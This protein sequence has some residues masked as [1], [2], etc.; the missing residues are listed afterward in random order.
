[1][2]DLEQNV[3]RRPLAFIAG[4]GDCYSLGYSAQVYMPGVSAGGAF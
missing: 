2:P 1:M 4:D 3:R